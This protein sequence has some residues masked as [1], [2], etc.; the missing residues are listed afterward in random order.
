V[1]VLQS[2]G[3]WPLCIGQSTAPTPHIEG[4]RMRLWLQA[5]DSVV[6]DHSGDGQSSDRRPQSLRG[7]WL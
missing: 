3:K 6:P 5:G 1:G 2:A 7:N 4:A